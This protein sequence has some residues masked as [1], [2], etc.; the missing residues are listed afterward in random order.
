MKTRNSQPAR[1]FC[2]PNAR[3]LAAAALGLAVFAAAEPALA[4]GASTTFDNLY[5]TLKA[6]AEG[7]LGKSLAVVMLI[8]GLAAGCLRGSLTGA[9]ICLGAALA[10]ASGP[11]MIDAI[12]S[13][14]AA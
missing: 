1:R 3:I 6:W 11:D 7:T 5:A 8:V 10:L 4:A 12:F 9:V 14:S 13:A 2:G